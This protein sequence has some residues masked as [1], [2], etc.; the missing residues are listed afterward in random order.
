MILP[1]FE[2]ELTDQ[3]KLVYV[4]DVI[5]GKLLESAK[6]AVQAANNTQEQF[7]T[8][9]DLDSA[10]ENAVIDALDAHETMSKQALASA[11]VRATIKDI[12]LKHTGLWQ[13]LRERAAASGE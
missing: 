5:Y 8:S 10:I 1:F 12:L 13:A 3:D 2:G 4:N 7:G 9:P 6:L 11:A